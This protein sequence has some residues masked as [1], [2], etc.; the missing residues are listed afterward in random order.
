MATHLIK[1]NYWDG[2]HLYTADARHPAVIEVPDSTPPSRSW[3]PMDEAARSALAALFTADLAKAEALVK[4]H[5]DK[6]IVAMHQHRADQASE[7]LERVKAQGLGRVPERA[8]AKEQSWK[9]GLKP[10]S[11]GYMAPAET[12]DPSA[13]KDEGDAKKVKLGRSAT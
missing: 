9:A 2:A 13:T 7:A 3:E 12:P 6:E 11:R 8:P 4:K 1:T 5:S 10:H